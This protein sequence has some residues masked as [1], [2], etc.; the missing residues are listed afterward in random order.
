M[1]AVRIAV[2]PSPTPRPTPPPT[3]RPSRRIAPRPAIVPRV[4][5]RTRPLA[6]ARVH[7]AGAALPT[8]PKLH[9]KPA[10][11]IPVGANAAGAGVASGVG[12][13]GSAGAGNGDGGGAQPCGEVTFSDIHG[14]RYDPA[15]GG[16]FVD[17]RLSVSFADGSSRS[18]VLDYPFYYPSEAANPWSDRNRNNPNFPT[19]LQTPPPALASHQPRLVRYVIRHSTRQG[20]TL[21]APC[22]TPSPPS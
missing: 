12:S 14:S 9:L 10:W 7:R 11:D 3:P 8:L 22:P 4:R 20:F 18:L 17:I 16:F 6:R 5:H 2:L 21:L 13:L 19:L 15:T 1:S